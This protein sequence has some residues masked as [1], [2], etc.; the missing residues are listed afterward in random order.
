M[1]PM[2][3]TNFFSLKLALNSGLACSSTTR[4][5]HNTYNGLKK[6]EQAIFIPIMIP[7]LKLSTS[8]GPSGVKLSGSSDYLRGFQKK[9]GASQSLG[10]RVFFHLRP[11]GPSRA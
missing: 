1:I 9:K 6:S 5:A 8:R 7:A 4:A 10:T 2:E 3:S 11:P